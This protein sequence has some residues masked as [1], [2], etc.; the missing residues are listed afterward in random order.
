MGSEDYYEILELNRNA[1]E[2]EIKKSYRKMVFKYHP[3]KN[4][5]DKKAEEK[6]KKVSEAYEVLSN[7]DKRAVYDRYG[8]NAFTPGGAGDRGFDFT[9]GFSTDF[10][11]IFQDFFGGGFGRST[12]QASREHLRGSDLRYDIEVS[13]EDVFKG[14]KVPISYATNVKCSSCSGSGSEGAVSSVKCGNCNGVG[15]IRTRKG[16]L[17]IEEVCHICNGEGEVIKNKCRKCGGNGRVRSEISLLVTVPKGIETGNKVRVNG[18]GEAG[19]RG[20]KDGDLYVYVRV[21]DHKFFTRKSSDL[22]CS[23]PI[24]MTTATLGGDIEIPSI[25]GSWARLKIPDGTQSGDKLMMRGK[26]M[27]E[28]NSKDKRGDMYVH[29]TVETPIKL[30]KKQIELLKK[31]EE[32]SN[33]NCSPKYQ[34][35]FKKIKD[36]WNDINS[37]S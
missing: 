17:T 31:F 6:F 15:S 32:E 9:S 27:P 1:S 36:L 35:F 14:I 26:G 18:K 28:V 21:K 13:L 7:P 24:K 30:T 10:S 12:R 29:I 22:H 37:N 3:D 4:P 16:F 20:A 33:V 11:D 19:F 2:E 34:G 23:V 8:S 5:G 25:D